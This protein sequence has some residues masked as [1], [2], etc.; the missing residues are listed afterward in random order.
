MFSYL[1]LLVQED[2][3]K[4][5]EVF[6]LI[7]GH[8]HASIDQYFSILARDIYKSK[9]I[10][11]PLALEALLARESCKLGLSG[12]SSEVS[13]VKKQR[14]LLVRK[15]CV[16]FDMKTELLKHINKDIKY[17]P[18]PHQFLFEKWHGVTTMQYKIFSTHSTFLPRRPDLIQGML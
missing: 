14:P 18:V 17:H 2:H 15:L 10:G 11:S 4:K 6:F 12:S 13:G 16:I 9:F 8:T 5:L 3:F 1:S 7:V